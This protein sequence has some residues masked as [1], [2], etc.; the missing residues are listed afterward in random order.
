[1]IPLTNFGEL[2]EQLLKEKRLI[3][4]IKESGDG[5]RKIQIPYGGSNF[6]HSVNHFKLYNRRRE[7]ER[8]EQ[9]QYFDAKADK[10]GVEASVRR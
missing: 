9:A 4:P 6:V 8:E 3:K 2:T 5:A 1:M 10:Q 7:V